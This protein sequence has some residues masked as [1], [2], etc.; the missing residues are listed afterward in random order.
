MTERRDPLI[1]DLAE[2]PLPP[3]PAPAEAPPLPDAA[4]VAAE[5][6]L[7]GAAGP[8]LS[9]LGRM[10]WLAALGLLGL[11][12]A[13]GVE[14]FVA[15][16]FARSDLLGWL[17]TGLA[18]ALGIAVAGFA[19][20]ELAALSRV[21]RVGEIRR[22]AAGAVEGGGAEG[23]AV[24]AAL[25]RL[26]RARP[27]M[28][29]PLARIE[30]ARPETPDAGALM[31]VAERALL[32]PLDRRAEQAVSRASRRVAAV[33]AIIPMPVA[34]ILAVL[35]AN[36]SMIREVAEIYGGRA[37]FLGS[38]RLLRAVAAHLVATGA[39][40]ATDDLLGPMLGGGV[41]GR[42]SRRFGEAAVNAALTARV[43]TA[44][45]EVCRPLPF[46]MRPP[47]RAAGLVL[48]AL[49]GWRETPEGPAGGPAKGAGKV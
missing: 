13:I 46:A 11:W 27:E 34:D 10:F 25:A 44:A 48:D 6:V 26:Y 16:L 38:W 39:V 21:Q 43:G 29:E 33:T 47:P 12:M 5:R 45:I 3:A 7:R 42:L 37:G 18:A 14:T 1:L 23:A 22:L 2:T 8:G 19:L 36:L 41:L 40:A 9:V 35:A 24:V 15:D 20:R 28:A 30:A 31:T 4:P 32:V 17:A 49:R